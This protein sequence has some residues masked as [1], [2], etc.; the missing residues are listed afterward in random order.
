MFSVCQCSH[1]YFSLVRFE[2]NQRDGSRL[3]MHRKIWLQQSSSLLRSAP[4][5][6]EIVGGARRAGVKTSAQTLA[7]RRRLRCGGSPASVYRGGINAMLQSERC[8]Q[9]WGEHRETY[10][11]NQSPAR[12]ARMVPVCLKRTQT[13]NITGAWCVTENDT[14]GHDWLLGRRVS[15]KLG[16][17]KLSPA[18]C[19]CC[20]CCSF[21]A[22]RSAVDW[23]WTALWLKCATNV[24]CWTEI[25]IIVNAPERLLVFFWK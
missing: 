7:T 11:S 19:L 17:Q 1:Y 20:F 9:S 18:V 21:C 8:R 16:L 14:A 2:V 13:I 23:T 10:H 3:L 5:C 24:G 4:M 12:P 22:Q 25:E 6:L 15:N